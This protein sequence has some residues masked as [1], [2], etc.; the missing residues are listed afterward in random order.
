MAA[1]YAYINKRQKK[2]NKE[3]NKKQQEE[4]FEHRLVG[5]CKLEMNGFEIKKLNKVEFSG[6]LLSIFNTIE[7]PDKIL[8]TTLV[9]LIIRR[10]LQNK[11]QFEALTS[12]STDNLDTGHSNII[13]SENINSLIST[14]PN[15]TIDRFIIP[16]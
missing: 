4:L 11:D 16:L 5:V 12:I 9:D 6:L 8:K 1:T 2:N 3:D 14:P 7:D 10:I 15:P 13:N